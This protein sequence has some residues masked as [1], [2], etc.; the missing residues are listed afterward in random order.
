MVKHTQNITDYDKEE[1]YWEKVDEKWHHY[2]Q[3]NGKNFVDG[4]QT[5]Y[6]VIDKA[7]S[8]QEVH[9]IYLAN[10]QT[11]GGTK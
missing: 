3:R 2:H 11:H 8:D 5:G 1:S 10:T 4:M 7:L 6:N 9:E